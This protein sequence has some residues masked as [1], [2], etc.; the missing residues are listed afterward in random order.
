MLSA[1][2][3]NLDQSKTCC[4]VMGLGANLQSDLGSTSKIFSYPGIDRSEHI[5]FGLSICLSAK[6]FT[7]AKSFDW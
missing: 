1:V 6:T 4:L 5:G 3:F 2:C 7:L